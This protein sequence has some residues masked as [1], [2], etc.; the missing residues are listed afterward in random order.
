MIYLILY[1]TCI[2]IMYSCFMNVSVKEKL[3]FCIIMLVGS[4]LFIAILITLMMID[5]SEYSDT[6]KWSDEIMDDFERDY[7][8]LNRG[9]I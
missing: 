5:C 7:I 6:V 1:I 8:E 3:Y 4:P 9:D 2:I